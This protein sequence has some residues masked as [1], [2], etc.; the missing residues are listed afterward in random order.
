MYSVC[1]NCANIMCM[2]YYSIGSVLSEVEKPARVCTIIQARVLVFDIEFPITQG[3]PVSCAPVHIKSNG[4]HIT[5]FFLS[6]VLFHHQSIVEPATV[7]KLVS[8]LHRS[9]G[10]VIKK[11]PR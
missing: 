11:K 2:V 9:T 7:H 3:Y 6:K 1:T 4:M 5:S 10:E 8:Q